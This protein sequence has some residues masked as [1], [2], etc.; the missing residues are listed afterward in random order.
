[1]LR[2]PHVLEYPY[3]RSLGPVL[4]RFF[5]ELRSRRLIGIRTRSGRVLVPPQE[6]DPDT[7]EA[8]DEIVPV[9][10]GGEIVSYAWVS[11]PRPRQPLP[12]P[13]AFALI[14][15]DGADTAL[16]HAVDARDESRLAPGVRVVPRFADAPAG[17][18]RDI[19]C[20][21]LAEAS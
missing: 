10:P 9:G 5:T 3:R 21:D 11:R 2:G 18:I 8:L 6:Y 19:V 14:R 15:L 17:G 13:F 12:H 16:L 4:S 20:F 7:G 1:V